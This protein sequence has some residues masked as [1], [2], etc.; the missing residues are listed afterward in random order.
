MVF[1]LGWCG[2]Y[3]MEKKEAAKKA[4]GNVIYGPEGLVVSEGEDSHKGGSIRPDV[5]VLEG[6][7][8]YVTRGGGNMLDGVKKV[9]E[10]L[11]HEA[12][13]VLIGSPLLD[14]SSR[15]AAGIEVGEVL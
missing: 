12:K 9:H 5:V 8:E 10:V 15:D 4:A 11:A 7:P 2:F 14:V 3:E 1:C 6:V 13:D